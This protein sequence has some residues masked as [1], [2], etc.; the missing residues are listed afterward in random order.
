MGSGVWRWSAC[1]CS[2]PTARYLGVDLF[3]VLSGYVITA[4]LLAERRDSGRIDLAAFWVRRA[5]RLF[6]A[7]LLLMPAIAAYLCWLGPPEEFRAVRWDALA[8]LGYVAKW[9]A[10]FA[11][12]S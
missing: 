9:H 1:F 5:R 10:I 7:L 12:Q 4:L 8:T 11:G 2:T 6:P 3:F